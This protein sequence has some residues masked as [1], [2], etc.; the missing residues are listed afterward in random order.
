[1]RALAVYCIGIC[2][3]GIPC[4]SVTYGELYVACW[5]SKGKVLLSNVK[6]SRKVVN[7]AVEKSVLRM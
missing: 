3:G 4:F 5:V 1:M 7:D 2:D 6:G